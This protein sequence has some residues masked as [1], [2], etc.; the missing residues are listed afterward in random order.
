MERPDIARQRGQKERVGLLQ[1]EMHG[2]RAISLHLGHVA[3]DGAVDRAALGVTQPV[4]GKFY[5]F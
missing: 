1:P 5:V 2:V 3:E 4:E